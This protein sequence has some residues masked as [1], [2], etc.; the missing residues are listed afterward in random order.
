MKITTYILAFCLAFVV[1]AGAQEMPQAIS[2]AINSDDPAA[3]GSYI[4][5]SNVDAC[6]FIGDWQYTVL[7]QSIRKGAKK[8]FDFIIERKADV[9]KACEGYVPPIMHAAKYGRIDMIKVLV[10]KGAN[11]TFTYSGSYGP[12]KGET[13]LSY[14]EK[15]NQAE[16][17][18][19]LRSLK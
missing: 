4:S 16:V 17:A 13:P 10:E 19:Y 18:T 5:S 3:L 9:N 15:Y 14:A 11:T 2:E 8:C 7:S 1:N 12:A 6:Y